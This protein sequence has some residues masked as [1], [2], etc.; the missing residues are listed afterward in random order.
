MRTQSTV[1]VWFRRRVQRTSEAGL[2]KH[3]TR[4]GYECSSIVRG[5]CRLLPWTLCGKGHYVF[6]T[7]I[8]D[9]A[10]GVCPQRLSPA[11]IGDDFSFMTESTI[12][13]DY[14]YHYCYVE[15][16]T[17][18][19][20]TPSTVRNDNAAG[21]FFPLHGPKDPILKKKVLQTGHNHRQ[22]SVVFNTTDFVTVL[23]PI[24]IA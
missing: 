18:N 6:C 4:Y 15:S 10:S 13:D 7:F 24:C 21:V 20:R 2:G 23:V 22:K 12:A 17:A 9:D 8:T 16:R 1:C 3:A 5:N 11:V 14:G 19:S